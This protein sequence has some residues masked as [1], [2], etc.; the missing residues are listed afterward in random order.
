MNRVILCGRLIG[1]PRASYTPTGV[2]VATFSLLVTQEGSQE[3]SLVIP[4]VANRE[5]AQELN[6][7][8]ER[9]HRVNL[10]GYL[11]SLERDQRLPPGWAPMCVSVDGAYFV[12]PVN[13][14]ALRT[15]SASPCSSDAE[16]SGVAA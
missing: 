2:A 3:V 16:A 6:D 11:R 5:L 15:E 12:D 9:G 7:W 13:V 8:G 10:E 4:C 14:P 1:R